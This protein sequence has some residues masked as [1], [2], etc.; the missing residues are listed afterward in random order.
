[1]YLKTIGNQDYTNVKAITV[2]QANQEK[3]KRGVL[4]NFRM[5]LNHK[6]P[7]PLK[8][9]KFANDPVSFHLHKNRN[10]VRKLV[11]DKKLDI[12]EEIYAEKEK[13]KRQNLI[14]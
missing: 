2:P 7:M 5:S 11:I 9:E 10:F 1:M 4:G 8:I 3:L 12:E 13:Q 14:N 6:L